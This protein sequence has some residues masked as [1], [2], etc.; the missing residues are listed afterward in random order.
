MVAQ[1]PDAEPSRLLGE[2]QGKREVFD[3]PSTLRRLGPLSSG[4]LQLDQ[5]R[6]GDR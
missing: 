4:V 2:F 1:S 5:A 6:V 3:V